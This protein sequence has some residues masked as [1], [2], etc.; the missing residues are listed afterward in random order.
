MTLKLLFIKSSNLQSWNQ[1]L[2]SIECSISFIISDSSNESINST[3]LQ[4]HTAYISKMTIV[5]FP[6]IMYY[7]FLLDFGDWNQSPAHKQEMTLV[8]DLPALFA[9]N[10]IKTSSSWFFKRTPLKLI[11]AF[12]ER[13]K[14]SENERYLY[15]A[16]DRNLEIWLAE[17]NT[18]CSDIV[19]PDWPNICN[20]PRSLWLTDHRLLFSTL[21]SWLYKEFY[22]V[23]S[24]S[25][26]Q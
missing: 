21:P 20:I 10:K 25:S 18:I 4:K 22:F 7:I 6:D 11:T 12:I 13:K 16:S 8:R 5:N 19:L 26:K 14:N 3:M 2:L 24:Y 17:T 15:P 23:M 9:T 1:C